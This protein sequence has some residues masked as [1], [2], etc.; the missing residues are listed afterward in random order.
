M[1]FNRSDK[2]ENITAADQ[3]A[4]SKKDLSGKAQQL[5]WYFSQKNHFVQKCGRDHQ[6]GAGTTRGQELRFDLNTNE[7]EVTSADDRS[8]TIIRQDAP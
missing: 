8:E 1:A 7:I 6:K 4:F 2:L 3:V 5:F